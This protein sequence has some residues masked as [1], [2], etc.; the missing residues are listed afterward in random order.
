MSAAEAYR[1]LVQSK[2]LLEH[3]FEARMAFI[4]RACGSVFLDNPE[5]VLA[6]HVETSFHDAI[7]SALGVL[8]ENIGDDPMD[9]GQ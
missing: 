3:E 4:T 1:Q 2:R 6:E 9:Q 7:I 8:E 5:D